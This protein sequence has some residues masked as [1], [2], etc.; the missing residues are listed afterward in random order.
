MKEF[1]QKTQD[2]VL[3][4][5]DRLSAVDV[6]EE[7]PNVNFKMKD[8]PETVSIISDVLTKKGYSFILSQTMGWTWLVTEKHLPRIIYNP[9]NHIV[10]VVD[11]QGR[12]DQ[13][14]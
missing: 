7:Y 13:V 4:L 3:D 10:Q 2:V 11:F 9:A 5:I 8:D 6:N 12:K 1:T 14:L